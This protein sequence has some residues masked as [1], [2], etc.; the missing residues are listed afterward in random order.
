MT[1]PF[2]RHW[3]RNQA[4]LPELK[5]GAFAMFKGAKFEKRKNRLPIFYQQ[6]LKFISKL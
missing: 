1:A 4:K 3:V 6:L 5:G 2:V